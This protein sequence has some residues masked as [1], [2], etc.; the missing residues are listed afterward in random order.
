MEWADKGSGF[1]PTPDLVLFIADIE[2]G[3]QVTWQSGTDKG[4]VWCQQLNLI[5]VK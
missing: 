5:E 2:G 1:L 4:Q 3:R